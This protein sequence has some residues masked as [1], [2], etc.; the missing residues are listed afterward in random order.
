MTTY[1]DIVEKEFK[2]LS[3]LLLEILDGIETLNP[4]PPSL[5]SARAHFKMGLVCT[6]KAL[7]SVPVN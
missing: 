7:E 2:D 5:D 1:Y 3:S 6:K 4:D